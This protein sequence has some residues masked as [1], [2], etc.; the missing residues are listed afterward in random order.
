MEKQ[1]IEKLIAEGDLNDNLMNYVILQE[2]LDYNK[3]KA[4]SR[5]SKAQVPILTKLYLFSETF[6]TN[7]T[8]KIADNILQLQISIVGLGRKEL[9]QLF[10]R[11][12]NRLEEQNKQ[13]RDLFK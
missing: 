7:F 12:D 4:I 13:Q 8:K 1:K 5:I 3:L 9:V 2:L 6:N 11:N 10:T